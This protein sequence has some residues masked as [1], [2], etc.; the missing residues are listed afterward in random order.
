M[1][2]R[3]TN[4]TLTP[5]D[6]AMLGPPFTASRFLDCIISRNVPN[7]VMTRAMPMSS[8]ASPERLPTPHW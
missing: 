3:V 8:Q 4:F 6:L 5:T 1:V 7:S 2:Y